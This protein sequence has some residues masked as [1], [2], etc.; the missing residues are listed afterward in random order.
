VSER[1]L[2][3]RPGFTAH[4]LTAIYLQSSEDTVGDLFEENRIKQ[5]KQI[6]ENTASEKLIMKYHP[7][8][9]RMFCEYF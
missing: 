3:N 7:K 9:A 2:S 5:A 1:L 4:R 6:K 8:I